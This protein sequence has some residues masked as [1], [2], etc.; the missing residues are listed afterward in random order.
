MGTLFFKASKDAA[1]ILNK[2]YRE[3]L[4]TLRGER[5]KWPHIMSTMEKTLNQ[6]KSELAS[7]EIMMEDA[8]RVN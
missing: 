6:L 3:I 8:I 5:G 4:M 2:R 1:L 7:L